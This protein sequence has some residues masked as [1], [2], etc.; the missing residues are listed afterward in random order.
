MWLRK[1]SDASRPEK[2][3]MLKYEPNS[4]APERYRT[5]YSWPG[6]K[7]FA[8]TIFD[9]PDYQT[10]ARGKAAYDLLGDLGIFTT[11]GIWPGNPAGDPS[12]WRWTCLDPEYLQWMLQLQAK[13]FELGWHGAGPRTSCRRETLAGLEK[14][15]ELFGNYPLTGSQHFDCN[16]NMYWGDERLTGGLNRGIYN[17]LTR[18]THHNRYSGHVKSSDLWWS[19]LCRQHMKY[20][21]SFAF[22]SLN[23]L[24]ECPFMPYHDPL[25]PDVNYW[26]G[27]SEGANAGTFL[28]AVTDKAL[29]QLEE[30]GGACIMYTHFAYGYID[31]GRLN[32]QFRAVME[33]LSKRNGWFVPV[34]TLLNFLQQQKGPITIT[35]EERRWLERRWLTHKIRFGSA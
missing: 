8:F 12:E 4:I 6:G 33:R 7:K 23:T 3:F 27:S 30:E 24:A 1:N 20:V 15:R 17:L 14:F 11:K 29:D 31:D 28:Q 21:R 5:K 13:G 25:R 32:P 16:E 18:W 22:R 34:G 2:I 26:Y 19:D 35:S 10:I 9:D